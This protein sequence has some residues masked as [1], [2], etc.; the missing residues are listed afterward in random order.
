M[1]AV[2][3]TGTDTG[4]G[5]TIVAGLLGRF[6]LN[7]G[8]R[9][10]TQKWIQTGS[11]NFSADIASHLRLM[12][13]KK[14]DIE[15]YLPYISPYTFKFASSPHL[16]AGLEKRAINADKIK[17]S[18]KFLQKRFD[19]V[20]VEG[21]GGAL[22]PFNKK[23]L[24]IDIAR[25]LSLPILIVAENKLGAINHTLMTVEALKMRNMKI[26]GIIFN[27]R[28]RRTNNVIL[29][30]N[31]NIIKKLTGEKILG[32]LPYNKDKNRLYQAFLPIGDKIPL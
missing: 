3:I 25:K 14:H 29:E 6:L 31:V 15:N 28:Y 23:K 20:I 19:F 4:V 1:R 13:I 10:I 18:F 11:D 12:G 9:V 16:A 17:K 26:A 32:V 27:N 7:K 24:V 2:F 22:V 21:I 30:D 8:Y 5:K